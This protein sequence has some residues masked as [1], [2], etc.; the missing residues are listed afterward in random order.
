MFLGK[1][2]RIEVEIHFRFLSMIIF[3]R[4]ARDSKSTFEWRVQWQLTFLN[5]ILLQPLQG[6][7]ILI[8]LL[9]DGIGLQSCWLETLIMGGN[10][11]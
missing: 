3:W 4:R 7:P 6:K 8:M 10:H 1:L 2:S 9:P 11:D 5:G